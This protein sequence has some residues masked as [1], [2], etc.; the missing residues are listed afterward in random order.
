[1]E[2][3]GARLVAWALR[4]AATALVFAGIAFFVA[5]VPVFSSLSGA[6]RDILGVVLQIGGA[7]VAL[8]LVAAFISR[9]RTLARPPGGGVALALAVTLLAVPAWLVWRLQPFLSEWRVV[10]DL[11]ASSNLLQGAN[12]NMSGVVLVPLA[13]ALAPPFI[14]LAA[15]ATVVATSIA[16]AILLVTKSPRFAHLYL[17]A[18]LVLTALVVGSLRGAS[19]A[20]MTVEA[21]QPWIE[22]SRPRAE[23]YAQIRGVVDR[24][25]AAVTPTAAALGWAWLAYAI[26]IPPVLLSGRRP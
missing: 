17:A 13:G 12:A 11:L 20:G 7:W 15:L 21:L 2:G 4:T 8:G 18:V 19:A 9:R 5:G 22:E 3:L 14:E 26:W 25:T 24:Y 10:A 16:T 6:A 1:M 23:E